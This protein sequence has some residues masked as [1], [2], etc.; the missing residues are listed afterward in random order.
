MNFVYLL[1]EKVIN[2]CPI[3]TDRKKVYIIRVS[4]WDACD[5]CQTSGQ[6]GLKSFRN[7]RSWKWMLLKLWPKVNSWSIV[8]HWNS[9]THKGQIVAWFRSSRLNAAGLKTNHL[10]LCS[11]LT[12]VCV[13]TCRSNLFV[14][15]C[16]LWFIG[17]AFW[18]VCEKDKTSHLQNGTFF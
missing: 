11:L 9:H 14:R 10:S 8:L 15:C 1:E 18:T 5:W 4:W 3:N 2:N 6:M 17:S 12:L 13:T 16:R 7:S